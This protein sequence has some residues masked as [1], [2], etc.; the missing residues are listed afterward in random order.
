VFTPV[1]LSALALSP[2][3]LPAN[4]PGLFVPAG[5]RVYSLK[6][7]PNVPANG[8]IAPGGRVDVIVTFRRDGKLQSLVAATNLLVLAVDMT[9]EPGGKVKDMTLSVAVD[10]KEARVLELARARGTLAPLLRGPDA[11][12]GPAPDLDKLIEL[13]GVPEAP[14]PRPK[15]K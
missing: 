3:D 5:K 2:A 9:S 12:P 13:L 8:F 1:L 4:P 14:A 11:K 7:D 10:V 15:A 6:L